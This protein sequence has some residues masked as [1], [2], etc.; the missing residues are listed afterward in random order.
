MRYNLHQIPVFLVFLI[1]FSGVLLYLLFFLVDKY[2]ITFTKRK[3]DFSF[4]QKVLPK[5]KLFSWFTWFVISVYFLLMNSPIITIIFLVG[6]YLFSKGFW[7][8][9]YSGIYFVFDKKINIGD[10]IS[11]TTLKIEGIVNKL[12]LTD[13]ELKKENNDL[14]YIPYSL[15]VKSPIVK[16]EKSENYFLN[17]FQIDNKNG[18]NESTIKQALLNC[19][20]TILSKDFEITNNSNGGFDIKVFT[21]TKDTAGY[22]TN[23]VENNINNT[24]HK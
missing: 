22:Q 5:F 8:N 16:S 14:I 15:I 2:Y 18:I 11:I 1:V 24:L 10:Y 9:I 7:E 3:K 21:Y 13:I 19:P 20:W 17:I 23:Y 6:I 12:L 4:L